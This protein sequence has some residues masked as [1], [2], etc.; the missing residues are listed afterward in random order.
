MARSLN[1][2]VCSNKSYSKIYVSKTFVQFINVP[3][4]HNCS[5]KLEN[6]IGITCLNKI[7]VESKPLHR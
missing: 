5:L 4:V 2:K 1:Q 3:T 6:N 7:K